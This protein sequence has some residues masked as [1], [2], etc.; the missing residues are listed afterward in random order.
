MRIILQR[1]E[2][3]SVS[4]NGQIIGEINRGFVALLGVT[5][6]DTK[7]TAEKMAQKISKLRVFADSEGKTNLSQSEVNGEILVISQFTLYAD[8][9]KG[10]RP[11]FTAA[12]SPAHACEIYEYFA[13]VCEGLFTRAERG[14]FGAEMKVSLVND[15]PFT[16][17]LENM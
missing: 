14:V 13:D 4:V 2:Q 5:D 7:E 8:C 11:S 6:G 9:S 1:V 17:L 16:I 15:G 10:N 3:A 12:G